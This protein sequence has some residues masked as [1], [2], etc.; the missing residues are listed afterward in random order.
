MGPSSRVSVR[1]TSV[2]V[3]T[4]K[5][6]VKLQKLGENG[7]KLNKDISLLFRFKIPQWL[8]NILDVVTVLTNRCSSCCP[9]RGVTLFSEI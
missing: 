7:D 9:R 1:V 3:T 6:V 8:E 2:R 4:L 5:L